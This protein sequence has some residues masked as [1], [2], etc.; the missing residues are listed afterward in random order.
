MLLPDDYVH[1]HADLLDVGRPE[2]KPSTPGICRRAVDGLA[3][4]LA[5]PYRALASK[6]KEKKAIKAF[7]AAIKLGLSTAVLDCLAENPDLLSSRSID[8]DG[9]TVCAHTCIAYLHVRHC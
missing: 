5:V 6:V 9:D 1:N 8:L 3:R 4:N 7:I 2:E